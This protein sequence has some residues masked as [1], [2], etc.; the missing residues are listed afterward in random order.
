MYVV[1][2]QYSVSLIQPAQVSGV[3][4]KKKAGLDLLMSTVSSLLGYHKVS[5][6]I[7]LEDGEVLIYTY[8]ALR[9]SEK[10]VISVMKS[11]FDIKNLTASEF[12]SSTGNTVKLLS[13]E[14][15]D[16]T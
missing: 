3:A 1:K 5:Y 14:V 16:R 9:N 15:K 11:I 10:Q 4:L 7:T 6:L 2:D 8:S 12:L 13:Y